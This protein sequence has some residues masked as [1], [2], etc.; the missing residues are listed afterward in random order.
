MSPAKA[1]LIQILLESAIPLL[2][3]YL[4]DWNLY[5][6]L[7]FYMMDMLADESITTL[8]ARDIVKVGRAQWSNTVYWIFAS[9][10]SMIIAFGAIHFALFW[11]NSQMDFKAELIRFWT[12]KE[13][14]LEQGYLLLPLVIFAAYQKYKMEFKRTKAYL[15]IELFGLYLA[16]LMSYVMIVVFT[17]L[18]LAI[19]ALFHPDEQFFVLAIVIVIA[20]YKSPL[21]SKPKR[22]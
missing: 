10:I 18:L 6:I 8:K 4:W 20:L 14:G 17:M 1:R 7:L 15:K 12:Y 9:L 11:M 19:A 5:F 13:L 2:G 3:F 22:K 21:F 16:Q